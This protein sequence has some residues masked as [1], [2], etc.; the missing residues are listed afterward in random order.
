MHNAML[1]DIAGER[2]ADNQAAVIE[3]SKRN[4]QTDR[5]SREPVGTAPKNS[6]LRPCSFSGRSAG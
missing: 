1:Q 3:C 6:L 4:R 2:L 5:R